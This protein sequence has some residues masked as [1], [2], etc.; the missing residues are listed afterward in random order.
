MNIIIKRLLCS[1]VLT[2]VNWFCCSDDM[3]LR[4]PKDKL[5]SLC[6]VPSIRQYVRRSDYAFYQSLV[7]VLIP[8]VLRPIPSEYLCSRSI[9]GL[10]AG[11]PANMAWLWQQSTTSQPAKQTVSEID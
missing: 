6:E 10:S 9:F 1:A 11:Q 8:D 7:Q 3:E 2:C 5:L 4:L